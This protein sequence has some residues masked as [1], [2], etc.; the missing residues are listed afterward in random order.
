MT[1]SKTAQQIAHE[2]LLRSVTEKAMHAFWDVVV[3][4]FPEAESGDLSPLTTLR[5]GQAAE[6]AVAE[7]VWANVPSATNE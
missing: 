7:W 6:N 5:F 1:Q 2:G 3:E 4:H